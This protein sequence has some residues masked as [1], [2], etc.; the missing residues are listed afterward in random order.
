MNAIVETV[1]A[2]MACRVIV[3]LNVRLVQMEYVAEKMQIQFIEQI[4]IVIKS[5]F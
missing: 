1:M 3:N 5:D 2:H 4:A